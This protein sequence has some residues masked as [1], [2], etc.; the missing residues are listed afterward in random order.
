MPGRTK[1]FKIDISTLHVCIDQLHPDPFANIQPFETLYQLAFNRD[2]EKPHPCPLIGSARL[3]QR[4]VPMTNY[5][6]QE[7]V[8]EKL[9][10]QLDLFE[11][12]QISHDVWASKIDDPEVDRVHR[13]ILV[14]IEQMREKYSI[15]TDK[16]SYNSKGRLSKS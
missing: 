14:L 2:I 13:E 15:L 5:M 4:T 1:F 6:P 9:E 3:F 7:T 8:L 11:A 12:L 16:Y 10:E